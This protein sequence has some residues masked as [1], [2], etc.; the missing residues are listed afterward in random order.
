MYDLNEYYRGII[1]S[2]LKKHI[3]S[4]E[5]ER[6]YIENSTA[7]YHGNIVYTMY[8]PKLFTQKAAEYF[9]VDVRNVHLKTA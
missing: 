8:I 1:D 5:E 9:Y 7:R 3:M 4:A 6:V 2:N